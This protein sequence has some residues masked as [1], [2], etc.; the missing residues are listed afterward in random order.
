MKKN[1]KVVFIPK[2]LKK[3]T[4]LDLRMPR[5]LNRIK[6]FKKMKMIYNL[7]TLIIFLT[8]ENFHFYVKTLRI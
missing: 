4:L 8:L 7:M 6:N 3:S 1:K 5:S 2:G